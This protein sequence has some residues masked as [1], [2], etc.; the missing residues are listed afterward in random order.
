[1]R[2]IDTVMKKTVPKWWF[3]NK[4]RRVFENAERELQLS[5]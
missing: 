3:E 5:S 2:T 1:M 4:K